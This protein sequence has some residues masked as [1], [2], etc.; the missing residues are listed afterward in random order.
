M[1]KKMD[2]KR[3]TVRGLAQEFDICRNTVIKSHDF[4]KFKNSLLLHLSSSNAFALSWSKSKYKS[5]RVH[6][7]NAISL[8]NRIYYSET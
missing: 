6:K 4:R 8:L 3:N 7:Q 5:A 2:H 1:H